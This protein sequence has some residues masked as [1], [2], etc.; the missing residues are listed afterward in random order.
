VRRQDQS[1]FDDLA[2]RRHVAATPPGRDPDPR[3]AR[4]ALGASPLTSF[5]R[6]SWSSLRPSFL[7]LPRQPTGA[8]ERI[9][10]HELDLRIETA[11]VIRRPLLDSLEHRGID[12]EQERFAL[13]HDALD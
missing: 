13:G 1:P 9:A 2:S 5:T 6:R 12:P 4:S 3:H 11:Q 7:R 8:R 10:Q